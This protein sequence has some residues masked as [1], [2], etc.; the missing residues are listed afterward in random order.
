MNYV[1]VD[2]RDNT[3]FQGLSGWTKLEENAIW[4]DKAEADD[5]C[6]VLNLKF[7]NNLYVAELP[8]LN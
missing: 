7:D 8:E 1:I 5:L 2:C 6:A 4:Y 3:Y